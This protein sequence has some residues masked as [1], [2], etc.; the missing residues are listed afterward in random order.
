V[1]VCSNWFPGGVRNVLLKK[2]TRECAEDFAG[3]CRFNRNSSIH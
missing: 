2:F 1:K 3:F